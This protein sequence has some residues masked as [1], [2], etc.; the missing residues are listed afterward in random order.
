MVSLTPPPPADRL[1]EAGALRHERGYVVPAAQQHR[2]SQGPGN[3]AALSREV[4]G[5]LHRTGRYQRG[6]LPWVGTVMGDEVSA[7]VSGW[8]L[9]GRGRGKCLWIGAL[10][11]WEGRR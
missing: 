1:P 5:H 6:E 8:V 9:V 4:P 2:P 3:Q 7:L 10:H 11:A